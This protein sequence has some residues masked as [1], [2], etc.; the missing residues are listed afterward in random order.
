LPDK[1]HGFIESGEGRE[2]YFH[3]NSVA[4]K[5]FDSLSVGDEIRYVE[6]KDDLGLQ[7]SI[8]YS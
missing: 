3:R 8:V 6:E 4:R 5:E 2:V 7:A 1:N